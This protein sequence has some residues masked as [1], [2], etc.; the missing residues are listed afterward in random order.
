MVLAWLLP[1]KHHSFVF[2]KE[3]EDHLRNLIEIQEDDLAHIPRLLHLDVST[4]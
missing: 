1:G 3:L 2:P 4:A